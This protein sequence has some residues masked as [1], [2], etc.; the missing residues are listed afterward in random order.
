[1]KTLVLGGTQFV[2][3]AMVEELIARGH[4]V[5]LFTRGKTGAGLF[6][7]LRHLVGD[8]LESLSAAMEEEWDVVL[9]VSAYLPKAAHLAV[10]AFQNR[11]K[12]YVFVSTISIMDFDCG[13][14]FDEN[15]P[16]LTISNPDEAELSAETYGPLKTRCEEILRNA[17]DGR[18]TII[19]PGLVA[20]PHDH[21]DR[22]TFWINA[23]QKG[24]E[25][26]APPYP[27][28]E[29]QWIDARDLAA[30]TVSR[31]EAM[32]P[33]TYVVVGPAGP[34]T[35]REIFQRVNPDATPMWVSA[36]DFEA[37]GVH[38]PMVLPKGK[39]GIFRVNPAKAIAAGLRHRLLEHTAEDL[40]A[41]V[42]QLDR[43]LQHFVEPEQRD[44]WLAKAQSG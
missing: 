33:E 13:G 34:I 15:T 25:F 42:D 38:L 22:F 37:A 2:G 17:F 23:C 29:V 36:P 10:E 41:F 43:P 26:L 35:F 18:L 1:M 11:T 19:R 5:T 20:G 3:R 9:D 44:A 14:P 30:F 12:H 21:T 27:D 32:D 4:E 16:S 8:R 40:R 39:E 24:G 31:I 28:Q 6:P 7:Q